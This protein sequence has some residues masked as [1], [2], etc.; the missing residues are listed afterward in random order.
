MRVELA[1]TWHREVTK[2]GQQTTLQRWIARLTWSRAR[3]ELV[4]TAWLAGDAD[5]LLDSQQ[6]ATIRDKIASKSL[7]VRSV[8]QSCE[9]ATMHRF[10][11]LVFTL[12]HSPAVLGQW[13]PTL[14]RGVQS[15]MTVE[16]NTASMY[17]MTVTEEHLPPARSCDGMTCGNTNDGH[18]RL[19]CS[20]ACPAGCQ[21]SDGWVLEVTAG[22]GSAD[23]SLAYA[24]SKTAIDRTAAYDAFVLGGWQVVPF[25]TGHEHWISHGP[26]G[27]SELQS[28]LVDLCM[29]TAK[30]AQDLA[31]G[32]ASSPVNG[33]NFTQM[34]C[35]CDDCAHTC[36]LRGSRKGANANG[37]DICEMPWGFEAYDTPAAFDCIRHSN[38]PT[39]ANHVISAGDGGAC[40]YYASSE[41]LSRASYNADFCCN[42]HPEGFEKA[43]GAL[44]SLK[45]PHSFMEEYTSPMVTFPVASVVNTSACEEGGDA[46]ITEYTLPPVLYTECDRFSM[47]VGDYFLYVVNTG[48]TPLGM[49]LGFQVRGLTDDETYM[50]V[51]DAESGASTQAASL[52]VVLVL[53]VLFIMS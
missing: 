1:P 48:A 26:K 39:D 53:L 32:S 41:E 45:H 9:S 43:I 28:D 4:L 25:I 11:V 16:A 31:A 5:R 23:P 6:F 20:G 15:S 37:R 47:D 34:E 36:G 13:M 14:T 29:T 51:T 35:G 12:F 18:N 3:A 7:G 24:I 27:T 8:F 30:A 21:C 38:C 33:L 46:V 10:C 50:C 17:R 49:T 40:T 52:S 2:Q 22:S 42:G 44:P 19:V